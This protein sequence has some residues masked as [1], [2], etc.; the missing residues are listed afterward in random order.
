MNTKVQLLKAGAA[1]ITVGGVSFY[2]DFMEAIQAAM[3]PPLSGNIY[4]NV[5]KFHDPEM[6][7]PMYWYA[8]TISAQ[9][10]P[11]LKVSASGDCEWREVRNPSYFGAYFHVSDAFNISESDIT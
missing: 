3:R 11:A 8:M 9:Q 7:E 6:E 1:V 10:P 4:T 2:S 5:V